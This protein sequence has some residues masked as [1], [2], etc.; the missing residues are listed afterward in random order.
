[1]HKTSHY[2]FILDPLTHRK[3]VTYLLQQITG[4]LEKFI[5]CAQKTR[6]I[7]QVAPT[8]VVNT[9]IQSAEGSLAKHVAF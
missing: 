5:F 3:L 1:M 6:K 8:F 4:R 2:K 7:L 9:R